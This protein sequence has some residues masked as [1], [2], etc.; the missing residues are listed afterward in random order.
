MIKTIIFDVDGTLTDGGIILSDNGKEIKRFSA[1]DGLI[2]RMLPQIGI[3]TVIL[4]GRESE[5]VR[6]RGEDLNVTY[7][8]QGIQDKGKKLREIS[9]GINLKETAYIGDDLND[10]AAMLMCG[11][12]ACPSN[13]AEEIKGIC[14]YVSSYYG[15]SGAVRDILEHILKKQQQ[16]DEILKIFLPEKPCP[17]FRVKS[18]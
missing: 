17:D 3:G 5:A 1:Y 14:E 11:F 16:W 4:T 7:T 13:A 15:G 6:K 8:I 2:M 12:R 18:C 9:S 10:Y